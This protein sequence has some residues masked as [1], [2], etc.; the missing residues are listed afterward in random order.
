MLSASKTSYMSGPA[1][2]L[3]P[4]PNSVRSFGQSSTLTF[5]TSRQNGLERFHNPG[6]SH[7]ILALDLSS[8][9]AANKRHRS[10]TNRPHEAIASWRL[11]LLPPLVVW[12]SLSKRDDGFQNVR[13][14]D[15]KDFVPWEPFHSLNHRG[16]LL[17][18]PPFAGGRVPA[19]LRREGE[20]CSIQAQAEVRVILVISLSSERRSANRVEL[21]FPR[22]TP[23]W[24]SFHVCSHDAT[25]L[26][27]HHDS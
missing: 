15:V 2:Q 10:A 17:V 19:V 26:E 7:T 20:V 27:K 23:I 1:L 18:R 25:R 12:T 21:R 3:P 6:S 9:I 5:E 24:T 8:G 4:A 14:F 13:Q 16:I 22:L 11:R